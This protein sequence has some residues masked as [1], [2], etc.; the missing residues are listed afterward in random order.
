MKRPMRYLVKR[1]IRAALFSAIFVVGGHSMS[2]Q[3]QM[4]FYPDGEGPPRKPGCYVEFGFG[5]AFGRGFA[6]AVACDGPRGEMSREDMCSIVGPDKDV[7]FPD[8]NEEGGNCRVRT[9]PRRPRFPILKKIYPEG[10]PVCKEMADDPHLKT[11]DGV[12]YDLQA[13]GEF[14]GLASED[15]DL[16]IQYR[17]EPPGERRNVSVVTAVA[18]RVGGR[19]VVFTP[20]PDDPVQVDGASFA[21]EDG[22]VSLLSDDGHLIVREGSRQTVVWPDGSNFHVEVRGRHLNAYFLASDER[23]GRLT[24]LFGDGDGDPVNDFRVRDGA[25]LSSPPENGFLYDVFAE[26]WRV[27]PEASLFDYAPGESTA[28]FTDRS[29]PTEPA[30]LANLDPAERERAEVVCRDAGVVDPDLL[31]DCV[32]D[33][34]YTGDESFVSSAASRQPPIEFI[35]LREGPDDLV[36]SERVL[37]EEDFADIEPGTFPASMEHVSGEWGVVEIRGSRL[38]AYTGNRNGAIRVDLPES[39][40][41][42][43]RVELTV[44]LP[45]YPSTR[46]VVL[47]GEPDSQNFHGQPPWPYH[48]VW[49]DARRSGI[50]HHDRREERVATPLFTEGLVAVRLDVDADR[51]ALHVAGKRL[52]RVEGADLPRTDR[53]WIQS[54]NNTR[55]PLYVADVRIVA[56]SSR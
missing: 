50:L 41:E 13:A 27:D 14:V 32:I 48:Y 12:R 29:V 44:H 2:V 21:V 25:L 36:P 8:V 52:V 23:A 38:L 43:F 51:A 6:C 28:T 34:G 45:K 46:L 56:E 24:G 55:E 33:Y 17:L 40:P 35:A 1:S 10:H 3:A 30:T 26:S 20:D 31:R 15:D 49:L 7:F 18:A 54:A 4:D 11:F 37:F 22:D 42:R 53:L 5:K 47:T 39:L 16:E 9:G 19:R